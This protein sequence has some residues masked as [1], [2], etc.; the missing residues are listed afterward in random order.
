MSGRTYSRQTLR[1]K[2]F[3]AAIDMM[4]AGTS[5]PMAIAAK[6]KPTNHDGNI[7]TKRPGTTHWAPNGALGCTPAASPMKPSRAIR[8]SKKLYAGSIAALRRMAMRL[9]ELRMP[10]IECGYMNRASAEPRASV[11]YA[12]NCAGD[13]SSLLAGTAAKIWPNPPRRSGMT[14]TATITVM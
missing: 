8:P 6:A 4:E 13:S 14:T 1:V 7:C 3:A 12:G 9:F 5:A 10:V 2:R 11:A